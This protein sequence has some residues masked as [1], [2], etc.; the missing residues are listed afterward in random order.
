MMTDYFNNN[1]L[2]WTALIVFVLAI[3]FDLYIRFQNHTKTKGTKA[4]SERIDKGLAYFR[5]NKTKKITNDLYQEITGTSDAT[6]TRDLKKLKE[7]GV[8]K[9]HGKNRGIYYTLISARRGQK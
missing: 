2:F 8:L 6:A 1:M 3:F 9:Q 5:K 7:L 4:H